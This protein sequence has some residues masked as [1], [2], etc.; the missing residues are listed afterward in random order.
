MRI[1]LLIISSL[2]LSSSFSQETSENRPIK[3]VKR[4][5]H[6]LEISPASVWLNKGFFYGH[7]LKYKVRLKRSMSIE[8]ES[9]GTIFRA[10]DDRALELK[11]DE[12]FPLLNQSAAVF[13]MD[14]YGKG[15]TINRNKQKRF[16]STLR[17]GYHF[18]QHATPYWNY[19][20]WAYDS[21]QQLGFS[22]IRSFQSHSISAGLGFRAD[23]YKRLDGGMRQV[24]SHKWSLDYLGSVYYQLSSYSLNDAQQYNIRNIPN[25]H[26]V[27]KSGARFN[28]NYTRYLKSYFGIHFGVEVVYVP[29]LKDYKADPEYFVPRGGERIFPL[30]TNAYAGVSFVF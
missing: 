28:Y 20:Y 17:L 12:V 15:K 23:K 27:R 11:E 18:F 3:K 13:S 10:L 14:V 5:N 2:I 19:D 1:L 29:F 8:L 22:S 7:R 4:Q 24:A 30:F 6:H 25:P 21:T 9:N 16:I 26:D